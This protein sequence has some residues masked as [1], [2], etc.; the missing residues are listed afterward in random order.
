MFRE[1]SGHACRLFAECLGDVLVMFRACLGAKQIPA[2]N[3]TRSAGL[4]DSKGFGGRFSSSECAV[5]RESPSFFTIS[6]GEHVVASWKHVILF[7]K[8]LLGSVRKL[9]QTRSC[10]ETDQQDSLCC[11]RMGDINPCIKREDM[12]GGWATIR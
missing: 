2:N 6:F 9:I 1:C 7:R 11:R 5:S 10:C 8:F 4:W 12:D 3:N